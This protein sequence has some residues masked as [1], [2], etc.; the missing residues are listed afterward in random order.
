[1][2]HNRFDLGDDLTI[3]MTKFFEKCEIDVLTIKTSIEKFIFPKYV[4]R[5]SQKIKTHEDTL[6]EGSKFL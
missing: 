6:I 2:D 1:M 4:Y 5:Q 3:P